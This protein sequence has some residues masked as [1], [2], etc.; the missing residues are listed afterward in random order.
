M[1]K[2][3]VFCADGTWNHPHNKVMVSDGDTNVYKL[4][5]ALAVTS[6]QI[7]AYDDGVGANL[8]PVEHLFGGAFGFG[9]FQKIKDGYTAVSH[10]YEKGDRVFLFGFSRGA[11][12]ARSL[13]GMIAISGLPCANFDQ[14]CV[15]TAFQAYRDKDAR[16]AL[17]EKLKTKYQMD[18]D[19]PIAMLG[20]WDT[21]GT[22]GI[23]AALF[24]V[25]DPLYGFLD[26]SLNKKVLAAYHAVAIDERRGEFPPTLW[27]NAPAP[28]QIMEQ[29]WFTG[30]H[31]DVGGGYDECGLSDI[32]LSW[33]LNK[34]KL[35]GLETIDTAAARYTCPCDAKH[36]IDMVHESWNVLW[37][38]PK[39]REVPSN[40]TIANS[41]ALRLQED[42]SYRPP[43]IIRER[44]GMTNGYQSEEV[45]AVPKV[46]AATGMRVAS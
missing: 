37:G 13:A 2:N 44:L 39:R 26:T 22:L 30:V 42:T 6:K 9:L 20:V 15:E 29:V 18:S 31:C 24:Q 41:V 17:L 5:K 40:A 38:F 12:T 11:Y 36:S 23:P 8:M 32:T 25:P 19:A 4:Y 35:Q 3:I 43:N 34:A 27:T 16:P 21:V 33:M 45:V 28:G 10:V 14:D 1:S 7:T 46:L